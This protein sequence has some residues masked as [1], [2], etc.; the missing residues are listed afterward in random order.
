MSRRRDGAALV[1]VVL[2]TLALFGIGHG[3]LALSLGELA[4]S[5]ASVRYLEAK[6]AADGAVRRVLAD[7][8]RAW[9]DSVAVGGSRELGSWTVGR[10]RAEASVWR[11]SSE[12]W[13]VEGTGRFGTAALG[14][15]RMAW[16]LD[17]VSSVTK[18]RAVLTVG[19]TSPLALSGVVEASAPTSMD[20]P[21]TS[22]DCG[23]WLADLQA[24]YASAP[25]SVVAA[26][27][28]ADSLMP[29]RSLDV[30]AMLDEVDVQVSGAGSAGPVESFGA[31]TTTEAWNWGDPDRPWGPCG[32]F[33]ALRGSRG[34][35]TMAGV[36]QGILVVDGDVSLRGGARFYGLVLA[37][38]VLRVE[39]GASLTGMAIASGGASVA[40]TGKVQGSACWA[41][42]AIAAQ[43]GTLGRLRSVPGVGHLGPI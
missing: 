26:S 40:T 32:P 35:L 20:P 25:L 39:D 36:G 24:S 11:I 23:P 27:E 4:A 7:S 8:G 9:M 18:L 6:V 3:L 2:I 16:A 15:A 33:M 1:A 13:W 42:R 41:A 37:T 34:S 29:I 38:G 19:P 17:P 12:T 5:R 22:A 14:T 10:A 21:H 43:R 28:P 30:A 31:C